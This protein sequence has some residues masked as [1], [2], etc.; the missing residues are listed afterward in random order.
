MRPAGATVEPHRRF[1]R[2]TYGRGNG[3]SHEASDDYRIRGRRSSRC[4][5][6]HAAIALAFDRPSCRVRRHDVVARTP[7]R[8]QRK[9]APDRG[10]L[11][12]VTG[13][14]DLDE[15]LSERP[16]QRRSLSSQAKLVISFIAN[17][18]TI[19]IAIERRLSGQKQTLERPTFHNLRSA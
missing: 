8:G 11:G 16:P 5:N 13:L 6:H 15:A 14:F 17:F 18:P 7:H 1:H 12:S 2:Q 4:R 3:G 19:E 10:N 9:Q